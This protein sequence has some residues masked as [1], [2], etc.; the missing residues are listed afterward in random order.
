[1]IG[2]QEERDPWRQQGRGA[3]AMYSLAKGV[4]MEDVGA[5]GGSSKQMEG[6]GEEEMLTEIQAKS[7]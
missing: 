1:M 7:K 2:V 4:S 3:G 6:E 5:V